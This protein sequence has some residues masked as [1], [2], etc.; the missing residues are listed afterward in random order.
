MDKHSLMR[1][2]QHLATHQLPSWTLLTLS[3]RQK[4]LVSRC[5]W[6]CLSILKMLRKA[7][8]QLQLPQSRILLSL[9]CTTV[10]HAMSWLHR[11]NSLWLPPLQTQV[12]LIWQCLTPLPRPSSISSIESRQNDNLVMAAKV[13]NYGHD[14][15]LW[16]YTSKFFA[17]KTLTNL[18][19]A[20]YIYSN[21]PTLS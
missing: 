1:A 15:T 3:F 11:A 8:R 18:V 7:S 13:L 10:G 17:L 14:Q 4:C 5:L 19:F 2:M 12:H 9:A 21:H 6:R 20:Y 16:C